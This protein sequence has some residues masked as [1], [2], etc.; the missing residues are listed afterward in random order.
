MRIVQLEIENFRG[1]KHGRVVLPDHCVL[2]G[3]N[4]VGKTT[5]AEGLALLAGKERLTKPLCD[6]DFHGGS[7]TPASRFTLIAT[8]TGFGDGITQDVTAFP[9]WFL[10]ERSARPV[11]W[12]EQRPVVTM[13]HLPLTAMQRQILELERDL[14]RTRRKS[15]PP[16]AGY[17]AGRM[18]KPG[19][20]D[21][22]SH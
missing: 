14:Q 6:W 8:I 2:L 4:D 1:V 5:I 22:P 20:L 21:E 18:A 15:D 3:R 19:R 9:Q 13:E 16:L 7:P 17:N 10:G 12:L 11:W